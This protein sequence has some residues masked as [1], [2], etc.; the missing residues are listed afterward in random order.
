MLKPRTEFMPRTVA[1]NF[2]F[3][4]LVESESP[5]HGKQTE[6]WDL[7]MAETAHDGVMHSGEEPFFADL[8]GTKHL[9]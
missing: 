9:V 8:E 7:L 4:S 1:S 3:A 5:R 6:S 2:L